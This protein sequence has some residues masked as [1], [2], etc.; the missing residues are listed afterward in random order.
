MDVALGSAYAG[1]FTNSDDLYTRLEESGQR[2]GDPFWR[3]PLSPVYRKQIKSHVA[4]L[5]NVGGRRYVF[6]QGP[7]ILYA[8]SAGSC[9][10]AEFLKEFIKVE[11]QKAPQWA[12][13]DIAG[14]MDHD[15]T[16][17]VNVK[18]M[19]GRPVR[20]LVDFIEHIE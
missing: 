5:R 13:I 20:S 1:V 18:G 6:I 16:D 10:A 4:D 17:G 12:H 19:S 2:A 15:G 9:T 3:M 7:N 11:G 14:V 8:N